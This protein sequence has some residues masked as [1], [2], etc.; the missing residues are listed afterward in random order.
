MPE[1]S[2][3]YKK[4]SKRVR[5]ALNTPPPNVPCEQLA[6][7]EVI[8]LLTTIH[9]HLATTDVSATGWKS[10][11]A[12]GLN[13]FGTDIIVNVNHSVSPVLDFYPTFKSHIIESNSSDKV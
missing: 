5:M 9:K 13:F 2:K 11:M 1:V 4:V 6:M 8:K 3:C 10:S 7:K 12:V